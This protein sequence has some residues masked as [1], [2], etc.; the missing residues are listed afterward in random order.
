MN[1]TEIREKIL[2]NNEEISRAFDQIE[3]FKLNTKISSLMTENRA[4]QKECEKT[5]GHSFDENDVC[6]ICGVE[7]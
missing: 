1:G 4:L 2:A 7:R 6:R 3:I 5:F